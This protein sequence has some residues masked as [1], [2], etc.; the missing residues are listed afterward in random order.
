MRNVK[1]K[2]SLNIKCEND[3]LYSDSIKISQVAAV[4]NTLNVQS[5]NVRFQNLERRDLQ[6]AAEMLLYLN[7]CPATGPLK[8]WLTS[9]STFYKDLFK[10]QSPE[11][12]ILTLNRMMK[13]QSDIP[14]IK[15]FRAKAQKLFKKTVAILNLRFD[16]IQRIL[17]GGHTD[18]SLMTA[19]KDDTSKEI[20]IA[21]KQLLF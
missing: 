7:A 9:W 12:I 1:A 15:N 8:H 3:C 4:E 14:E 11:K 21:G 17:P 2:T 16:A 10:N 13:S 18:N 19:D 5:S 20:D 6:T